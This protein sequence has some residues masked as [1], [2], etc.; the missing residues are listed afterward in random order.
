MIKKNKVLEEYNDAW[1]DPE[2]VVPAMNEIELIAGEDKQ[3]FQNLIEI[4]DNETDLFLK[5]ILSDVLVNLRY[6]KIKDFFVDVLRGKAKGFWRKVVNKDWTMMCEKVHAALNLIY[7]EDKRGCDFIINNMNE[8]SNSDLDFIIEEL[9]DLTEPETSSKFSIKFLL[10]LA[11][12]YKQVADKIKSYRK[13]I[14]KRLDEIKKTG[15]F[16]K[17][18]FSK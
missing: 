9:Y 15:V 17:K 14:E 1:T 10:E 4:F 16:A 2:H 6:D 11:D 12:T 3:E 18:N 8:L 13:N 5:M 7:L